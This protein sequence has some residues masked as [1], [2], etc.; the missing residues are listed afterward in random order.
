[1]VWVMISEDDE[2]EDRD[3]LDPPQRLGS[4]GALEGKGGIFFLVHGTTCYVPVG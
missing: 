2:P 1:M 4:V 3:G